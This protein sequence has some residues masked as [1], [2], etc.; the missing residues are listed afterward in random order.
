MNLFVFLHFFV[1]FFV[2]FFA[3]QMLR[4]IAST[5][6]LLD[7][8]SERKQHSG[9]IPLIGGIAMYCG[10]LVA[11]VLLFPSDKNM[12][13][14]LLT[15]FSIVLIGVIDDING[16]SVSVRI[17]VQSLAALVITFGT[18]L[19]LHSLGDLFGAG[20]VDLGTFGYAVSVI[21]VVAC[22]NAFNMVD[23]ID[24]LAGILAS[25]S[26]TSLAVL[27][28]LNN[29]S[30]GYLLSLIFVAVLLPYLQSNL[31][32][33]PLKGKVFMG[34]AGAMFIGFSVVWL[35]TYGT[36]GDAPSFRPVTALWVIAL[37]LMD[38]AAVMVCRKKQTIP[39]TGRQR[40]P[41]SYSYEYRFLVTPSF[42]H[43]RSDLFV[44]CQ[45]RCY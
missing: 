6:S 18:S 13:I 15:S 12:I 34:D 2:A 33:S 7:I 20:L 24:G 11:A 26:F 35:L 30:Y 10:V 36:Q 32:K 1:A 43:D 27:F 38:M 8:P 45:H 17:L 29:D 25:V 22:I 5:L 19:Y 3:I 40:S 14:W 31:K 39:S 4:P 41:A 23:G 9:E 21:A 37:P 28:F 42:T 44:I 16:L